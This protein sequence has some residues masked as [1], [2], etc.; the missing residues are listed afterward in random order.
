MIEVAGF[1]GS[2]RVPTKSQK[3]TLLVLFEEHKPVM[4]RHGG[5]IGS[6]FQFHIMALAMGCKVTVHLPTDQ[7]KTHPEV[8]VPHPDVFLLPPFPFLVRNHHIVDGSQLLIATPDGQE[9]LRSG[10]WATIRYARK[11]R[12]PRLIVYPDGTVSNDEQGK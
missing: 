5:C 1:S 2:Q 7:R 11:V 12:C 6:D 9:R 4:V 3:Q 10:T 8:L